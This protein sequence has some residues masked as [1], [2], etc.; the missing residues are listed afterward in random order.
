MVVAASGDL[1]HDE[2]VARVA[3]AFG[4]GGPAIPAPDPAP[5]LPAGDRVMVASRDTTQAQICLG[6]PAL[7]RDHPDQWILEVLNGV[8]GEGMSCRLF[9]TVREERGLAYDVQSYLV[10]YADAGALIVSAGVDPGKIRGTVVAILGE[11]ARL[12][13]TPVP[14][15]ELRKVKA[16]L[17]GRLELR[18]E[19]TRHLAS[20]LGGQE[21]LHEHVH[22]LEE[23]TAEI[24]AV[25]A[26]AIRRVAGDIFRDDGLRLSVVA[27]PRAGRGIDAALVLPGGVA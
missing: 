18:L 27:P 17:S 22:S 1:P 20:W 23:A 2:I 8:L 26:E 7:H 13:D 19:E 21:A 9:L 15:A 6:V 25:D 12:R 16:Y 3:A 4:T 5:A 10:D 11:L 14:D 24:E